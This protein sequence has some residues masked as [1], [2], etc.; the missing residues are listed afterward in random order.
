[1]INNTILSSRET[2]ILNLISLEYTTDEIVRDL[3]LSPDTI[4]THRKRLFKKMQVRN[5]AGL[6]R[7]SFENHV[8]PL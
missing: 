3:F 1:M 8:L 6:I 5:V 7:K 2:Q 4:K